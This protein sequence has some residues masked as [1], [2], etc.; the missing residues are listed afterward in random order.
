MVDPVTVISGIAL[1]NKAFKEVKQLLQNGR[2]VADCGKQLTDWAKGCSQ[3]Q[4]EN[5]RTKLMGSSSSETAMKRLLHTQTVQRQREELREFMQLYGT[6]GS[7]QQFLNLEREA[8][9]E[10]K[11]AKE[12]AAKKQAKRLET[13]KNVGLAALITVFVG[14]IITIGT[15]VYLNIPTE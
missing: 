2:T 1:A 8:R 7:W 6:P 4:E 12:D 5:N 15:V 3:V 14:I 13:I 10:L 9:L 11:K